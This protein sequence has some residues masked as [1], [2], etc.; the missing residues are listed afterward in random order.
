VSSLIHSFKNSCFLG[1][2]LKLVFIGSNII[3]TL[4]WLVDFPDLSRISRIYLL[5]TMPFGLV[6]PSIPSKHLS[7]IGHLV[8]PAGWDFVRKPL[9]G[10]GVFVNSSSSD[11]HHFLCEPMSGPTVEYL[12]LFQKKT[13]VQQMP[14]GVMST[15][16]ID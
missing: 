5:Y 11:Y 8:D 14:R 10:G 2:L 9:P 3:I 16:G 7:G 6:I 13:N 4:L 12:E 15:L 1:L